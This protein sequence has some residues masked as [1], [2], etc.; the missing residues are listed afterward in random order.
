MPRSDTNT[1]T[2]IYMSGEQFRECAKCKRDYCLLCLDDEG[3][4]IP[5]CIKETTSSQDPV[6]SQDSL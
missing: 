5:S 4:C 3:I 1:L 2:R 6:L